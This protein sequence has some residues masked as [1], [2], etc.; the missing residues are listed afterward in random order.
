MGPVSPTNPGGT[1]QSATEG[2][3]VLP[4]LTAP[5]NFDDHPPVVFVKQIARSRRLRLGTKIILHG[6]ARDDGAIVSQRL[7]HVPTYGFGVP[8]TV[9]PNIPT[10]ARSVELTLTPDGPARQVYRIVTVDDVGQEGFDDFVMEIGED[11]AL[12]V[13]FLTDLSGGY[14]VGENF[15][16]ETSLGV[17][18][19]AVELHIDDMLD[20]VQPRGT[21]GLEA[22]FNVMPAVSTDLA[23]Y[24]VIWFGEPHY[25]PYFSI[26]PQVG[27]GDEPPL[28]S[29]T[30]PMAGSSYS[31]GTS[32]PIRWTAS[33][34][35][36]LRSFDL[37]ASYDAGESWHLFASELPGTAREFDWKLPASTG[38]ADVRV[39]VIARD[40][41]FQVSSDGTHRVFSILPGDWPPAAI[42]G[43]IDGDGDVDSTDQVLFTGV[44]IGNNTD[45]DHV[46][47]SDLS[48]DGIANGLDVSLMVQA[49]LSN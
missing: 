10:T 47:R 41:R 30:S 15:D 18:A 11:Q 6:D 9:I 25:S 3:D 13:E 27:F 17:T 36:G 19:D 22:T 33:D 32:V 23:R 44:L 29:V 40:T 4:C 26:R 2:V 24:A 7:E 12:N 42:P 20:D 16:V 48:G 1:G 31:G 49:I 35:Q 28:V 45:P 34:D 5:V 39:R 14:R 8:V 43:D 37:Q 38:I 21:L 46:L